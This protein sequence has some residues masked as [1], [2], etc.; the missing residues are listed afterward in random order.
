MSSGFLLL[1]LP[2]TYGTMQYEQKLLQPYMIVTEADLL[3][4][5]FIGN[6]SYI[7]PSISKIS[8]ILFFSDI[9]LYKS[10]GNLCKV[11]VPN[12]MSIYG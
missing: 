3:L 9:T 5:L 11:C 12:M 7:S 4:F 1:S 6:P 2:L 8:F 10:S